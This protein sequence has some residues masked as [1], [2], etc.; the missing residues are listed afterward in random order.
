VGMQGRV[1]ASKE[2]VTPT[3]GY[4][5]GERKRKRPTRLGAYLKRRMPAN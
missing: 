2:K 3:H 1:L 5:F 4:S